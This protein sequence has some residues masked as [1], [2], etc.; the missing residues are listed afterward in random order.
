[1]KRRAFISLVGGAALARPRA[2]RAQQ[3]AMPVIGFFRSTTAVPFT[4]LV[5]AFRDGLKESGFVE[6][7]NVWIEYR[8]ADNRPERLPVIAAELV[9][10]GA[11]VIVGNSLAA[12]A[13]KRATL[14]VPIVFITAEIQ[15]N[16]GW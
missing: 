4:H 14:T 13:V 8:F 11:A 10:K 6:G 1:M 7:E 9:Q 5:A 15:S 2:G 3:K 12:E 16:A